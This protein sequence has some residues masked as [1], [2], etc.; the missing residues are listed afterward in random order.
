VFIGI[1]K[2]RIQE[3]M[4][5]HKAGVKYFWLTYNPA[6]EKLSYFKRS[7]KAGTLHSD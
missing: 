7:P 4:I 6:V 1:I 5:R 2:K 3:K